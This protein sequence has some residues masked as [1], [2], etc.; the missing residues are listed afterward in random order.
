MAK[1]LSSASESGTRNTDKLEQQGPQWFPALDVQV[2]N[3]AIRAR[4]RP[5]YQVASGARC[6]LANR[7]ANVL[8]L[9]RVTEHR[10]INR[11]RQG[12]RLKE[13]M[14]PVHI[15]RGRLDNQPIQHLVRH[16]YEIYN[17]S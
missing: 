4:T 10:F 8:Q 1:F 11:F 12:G 5:H 13:P 7:L 15:D 3:D 17:I 16:T 9:V 14:T 6:C 2:A